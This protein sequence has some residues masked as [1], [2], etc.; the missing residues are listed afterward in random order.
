[1]VNGATYDRT[2]GGGQPLTGEDAVFLSDLEKDRGETTNLRR[3]H[4]QVADELMTL[5]AKWKK[6]VRAK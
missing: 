2:P 5:L 3:R 1:V 6:D 4:P